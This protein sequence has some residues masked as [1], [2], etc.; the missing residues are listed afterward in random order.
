MPMK[1]FRKIASS[2]ILAFILF[3]ITLTYAATEN[4]YNGDT[5][6]FP[7]ISE[8][9]HIENGYKANIIVNPGVVGIYANENGYK[10]D[11]AINPQGIGGSL[12][13][14]N[15][16]LDLIPEKSFPE[17]SDVAVTKIVTSQTV[18]EQGQSLLI[19]VTVQNKGDYAENFNVTAYYDSTAIETQT[20]TSLAPTS[21]TTLT[22]NW[23]TTGVSPGGYTI[24]AKASIVP[25]ETD[26]TNNAFIDGVLKIIVIVQPQPIQI[27]SNNYTI[28]I[29]SNATITD[30]TATKNTLHL[31]TSGP[32]GATGYINTTLPVGLNKT[33][34]KVFING[35]KLTPPPFPIITKNNTHYFI[36]FEF[37]LSTHKIT[38]QYAVADIATTNITP[39]K[40]I[41]GKGYTIR[42]NATIQNQ[43][44]YE[45]TFNVTVYANTTIIDTLT[46]II[47]TSGNSSTITFTW[48]TT[49]F[50]KGRYTISAYATSV[51]GETD[52]ADNRLI[53]GWVSVTIIGDVN[54]DKIV[55]VFDLIKVA[56][57]FGSKPGD[58]SWNPNADLKEDNIIDV[59][60]LIKVAIHFGET[61]P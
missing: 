61:T 27:G 37:T 1:N 39:T 7:N 5:N 9:T 26:I 33:E 17:I 56:I 10:L 49:G 38:I 60:D 43:G 53:G 28:T 59:F 29:E 2:L 46:N 24:F 51:P 6:I 3:S 16:K 32:P 36:Y 34:I 41:V 25:G 19:N 4:N 21:S 58:A 42:I 14:N 18:V 40:T 48:N 23:N 47:L 35:I 30:V 13:E 52:T 15:Y 54:G 8:S 50:A 57:A 11:L 22:F 12:E 31:T 44:D 20:V 45:E 55:D